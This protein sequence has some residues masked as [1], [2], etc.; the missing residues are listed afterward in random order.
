M[1]DLLP[2]IPDSSLPTA[3]HR[4]PTTRPQRTHPDE[5]ATEATEGG[6]AE[7]ADRADARH[8]VPA[9]HLLRPDLSPGPPGGAVRD[10]PAPGAA[11]DRH[12][13]RDGPAGGG[14]FQR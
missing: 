9:P 10:E 5:P 12:G 4:L 11:G 13:G 6:R 2:P 1:T 14:G 8:G 7:R 3:D